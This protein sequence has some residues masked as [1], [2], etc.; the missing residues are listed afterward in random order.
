MH[1]RTASRLHARWI[2]HRDTHYVHRKG[3]QGMESEEAHAQGVLEAALDALKLPDEAARAL[4]PVPGLPGRARL[5][6][7]AQLAVH[8]RHLARHR[9]HHLQ[10]AGRLVAPKVGRDAD[11]Y[12]C[13]PRQTTGLRWQSTGL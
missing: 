8:A 12:D 4:L 7:A 9:H 13:L 5:G 10:P 6:V 2:M 11:G 3:H 1:Q